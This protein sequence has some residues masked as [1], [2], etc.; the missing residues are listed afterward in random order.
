MNQSITSGY[1][2]IFLATGFAAYCLI[3]RN[4]PLHY[5][6]G[7]AY[8]YKAQSFLN[9]ASQND[10]YRA[11]ENAKYYFRKSLDQLEIL[12]EDDYGFEFS[13]DLANSVLIRIESLQ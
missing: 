6:L 11:G 7:I 2:S 9:D 1:G 8:Y 13:K 4:V 5:G 10:N 3:F 12:E